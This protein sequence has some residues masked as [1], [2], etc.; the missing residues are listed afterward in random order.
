MSTPQ[1]PAEY[2]AEPLFTELPGLGAPGVGTPLFTE[3]PSPSK[4]PVSVVSSMMASGPRLTPKQILTQYSADEWEQFVLEWVLALKQERGYIDVVGLGGS[5]DR[6]AD[7]VAFLDRQKTDGRWHCF[8]CKHYDAPLGTA[9]AYPEM[10]KILVAVAEGEYATMPERYVF[11]APNIGAS[12]KQLMVKPK[13]FRAAFLAAF[14]KPGSRLGAPYSAASLA[15]GLDL[16]RET[17]FS[18][19]EAATLDVILDQHYSTR[20]HA[21]RFGTPL[22]DR[23]AG[24]AP[25]PEHTDKEARYVQQLLDVY[26]EEWQ[27]SAH[28]PIEAQAHPRAG[29]H[30]RRQRVAFYCA[31]G[32]RLFARDSVPPGVFEALQEEVHSR[33]DEIQER[34]FATSLERVNAVLDAAVVLPLRETSLVKVVEHRDRAGICHQLANA[35]KLTW[36][37]KEEGL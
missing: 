13:K 4:V 28:S 2:H 33:V 20:Y 27:C 14:D 34:D 17:E 12:L 29:N 32:L 5:Y 16:A 25:P 10:L 23:P 11:V 26:N 19:F 7:I 24:S 36:C 9:K 21:Q 6:G 18:C 8:Q 37:R 30:L 15:R 1:R 31:E 35:D 3:L 22:P